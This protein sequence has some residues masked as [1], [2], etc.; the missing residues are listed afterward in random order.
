MVRREEAGRNAKSYQYLKQYVIIHFH[1]IL[2]FDLYWGNIHSNRGL[3]LYYF[4]VLFIVFIKN[5]VNFVC[6]S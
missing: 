6:E 4:L 3:L 2:L 5:R 1:F